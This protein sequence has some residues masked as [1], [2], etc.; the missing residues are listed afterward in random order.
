[1]ADDNRGLASA[2]EKT[3]REVAK[4]GGQADHPNGRGL[5]NADEKTK[6]EVARKGGQSSRGGG[7]NS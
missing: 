1:M 6:Q 2:D 4:K 5:Q 7:R 3:R